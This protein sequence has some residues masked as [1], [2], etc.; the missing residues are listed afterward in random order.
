MTHT[1]IKRL[2]RWLGR[3]LYHALSGIIKHLPYTLYLFL[4][5]LFFYLGVL[6][7]LPKRNIALRSLR[8]ALGPEKTKA[9]LEQIARRY[10]HNFGR[11]MIDLIYYMN[12]TDLV[13]KNVQVEGL[14]HLK[15][16]L[17][18]GNGVIMTGG[19]FGNF[20]LMYWRVVTLGYKVNVIMRR[21][22]DTVFEEYISTMR[23][24]LGMR[25]IYDL[26]AKKCVVE[27]IKALRN[28][29][30]LFILLDQNYGSSG[31]IFVDFFGHPA[32]T[33]TGPVVFSLRTKAPI[34]PAFCLKDDGELKHKII[35]EKPVQLEM[36]ENENDTVY[37]NISKITKIIESYVRQY[38]HEWGGWVHRRWKSRPQHEQEIIDRLKGR[39]KST[40]IN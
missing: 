2:K 7:M 6:V 13:E 22:H 10:F 23:R 20:L 21:V 15:E 29:E 4:A 35:I 25:A 9:E 12:H 32:A 8:T 11:G 33:A 14:D 16:A 27:C 26:P 37:H 18:E 34:L 38:P 40:V 31:R 17:A 19:H 36:F 3:S 24:K 28:N 30:V 1:R 5:R 39:K